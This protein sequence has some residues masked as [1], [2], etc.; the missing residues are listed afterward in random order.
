MR[1][2]INIVE[3]MRKVGMDTTYDT[4]YAML[5]ANAQSANPQFAPPESYAWK[6]ALVDAGVGTSI[7]IHDEGKGFSNIARNVFEALGH[8]PGRISPDEIITMRTD[9]GHVR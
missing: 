6:R 8:A 2:R 3:A 7:S 4:H 1:N 9:Q 5:V